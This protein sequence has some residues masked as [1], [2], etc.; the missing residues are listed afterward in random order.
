[1][2]NDILDNGYLLDIYTTI[3]SDGWTVFVYKKEFTNFLSEIYLKKKN[4]HLRIWWTLQQT[5]MANAP[6]RLGMN[7]VLRVLKFISVKTLGEWKDLKIRCIDNVKK[8]IDNAG[9]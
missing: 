9:K 2:V 1:M 6:R 8:R 7:E 5:N 4:T 3:N